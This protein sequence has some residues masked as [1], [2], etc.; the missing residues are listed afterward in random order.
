MSEIL[1]L[2]LV[3]FIF[4]PSLEKLFRMPHMPGF[5]DYV[6]NNSAAG[7]GIVII[8]KMLIKVILKCKYQKKA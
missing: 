7:F 5:C 2:D 1:S 6:L 4:P 3:G 8:W